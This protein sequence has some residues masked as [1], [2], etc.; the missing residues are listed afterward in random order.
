MNNSSFTRPKA[1]DICIVV[2]FSFVEKV[3]VLI[4]C[5]VLFHVTRN[6]NRVVTVVN[7]QFKACILLSI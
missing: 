3:Q 6:S 5:S 4:Q 7:K 1:E 2:L